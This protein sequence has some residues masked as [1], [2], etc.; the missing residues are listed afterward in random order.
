[1]KNQKWWSEFVARLT[2][3]ATPVDGFTI[4]AGDDA[5]EKQAAKPARQPRESLTSET[6]FDAAI[7]PKWGNF[8]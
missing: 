8:R 4:P 1:M 7:Y 3:G 6:E 5:Q 2:R